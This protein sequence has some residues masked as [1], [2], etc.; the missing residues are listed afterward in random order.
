MAPYCI[1][2]YTVLNFGGM[3]PI[4]RK[5]RKNA[6]HPDLCEELGSATGHGKGYSTRADRCQ[7]QRRVW[8]YR[9]CWW[10][11]RVSFDL[12]EI[13]F[14]IFQFLFLPNAYDVYL[15]LAVLTWWYL[16]VKIEDYALTSVPNIL[17]YIHI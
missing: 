12:F 11:P 1:K 9:H 7:T 14:E 4:C 16:V 10:L 15:E 5:S 2:I 17:L 3:I 6:S 8:A 13:C